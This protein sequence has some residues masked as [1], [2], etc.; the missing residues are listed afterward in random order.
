MKKHIARLFFAHALGAIGIVTHKGASAE[1]GHYIGWVKKDGVEETT[2]TTT[3]ED[4]YDSPKDEWYKFDDEK[5]SVIKQ[6]KI[7]TLDG[8]GEDSTAYILLY[9]FA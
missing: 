1:G 2:P 5:V 9:R 7:T 8:G 3:P 4:R 6:E